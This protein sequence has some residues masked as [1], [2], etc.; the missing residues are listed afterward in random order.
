MGGNRNGSNG[1][2]WRAV[3]PGTVVI[4]PDGEPIADMVGAGTRFVRLRGGLGNAALP[5]GRARRPASPCSVSPATSSTSRSSSNPWRTSGCGLSSA[6]KSSL[7]S[8]L[9][10]AKPKIA[11]YPFTTLAPNLGVVSVADDTPTIADV[12]GLIPAPARA[13]VGLDSC[14]TSSHRGAGPRWTARTP[15]PTVTRSPMSTP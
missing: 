13:A 8:V 5:R 2:I 12:P 6:G 9:S 15:S 7:I 3:P 10:A 1:A 11:D 4:G 14:A